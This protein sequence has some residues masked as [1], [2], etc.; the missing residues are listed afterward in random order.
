MNIDF[1][2][3]TINNEEI[4][5]KTYY[6]LNKNIKDINLK[7]CNLYLNV[8]PHPNNI[9]IDNLKLIGEKY[10]KNVNFNTPNECNCSKAFKWG[11]KNFTSDYLFIIESNKCIIK[12]FSIQ[13]M[14]KKFNNNIVEICLS[15]NKKNPYLE[16]LTSH[17]SIWKKDWLK[18]I[19]PLL[20]ENINYEYQLREIGLLDNKIGYTLSNNKNIYLNHIGKKYKEEK[21]FIL[22]NSSSD[23]EIKSIITNEGNWHNII[24]NNFKNISSKDKLEKLYKKIDDK[25][26][27]Y[28]WIGIWKYTENNTYYLRHLKPSKNYICNTI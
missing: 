13:K 18:K 24:Y 27:N 23:D 4:L 14:I 6:Y 17:P 16:Y 11:I 26:W 28:R 1:F 2:T 19:Y 3:M 22:A 21:K 20:S 25:E 15:P 10:F 8:D 12:D 9:N 5:E 7:N